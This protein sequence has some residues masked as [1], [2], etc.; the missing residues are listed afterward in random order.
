MDRRSAFLR[1]SDRIFS[2][3][4]G[5]ACISLGKFVN[6][7]VIRRLRLQDFADLFTLHATTVL[8]RSRMPNLAGKREDH[9]KSR[10][11]FNSKDLAL[12]HSET[13]LLSYSS[14]FDSAND[15]ASVL[16]RG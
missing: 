7:R 1:S 5:I 3:L 16:P 11:S 6:N 8:A 15:V 13:K 10:S 4:E 12:V 14:A 2:S 9:R